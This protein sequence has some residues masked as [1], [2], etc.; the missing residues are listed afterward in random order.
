MAALR[1]HGTH[2]AVQKDAC[3]ALGYMTDL[4][5]ANQASASALG[6]IE[7]L[8]A[9]LRA[10]GTSSA[11]LVNASF[12]LGAVIVG[13]EQLAAKAARLGAL[14]TLVTLMR[15]RRSV[16]LDKAGCLAVR[17]IMDSCADHAARALRAL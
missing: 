6:A 3:R 8:L 7:L 5:P 10:P 16:L 12:A 1:A 15:T 11:A 4:Q 14:E 17:A 9:L 13:N 2:E